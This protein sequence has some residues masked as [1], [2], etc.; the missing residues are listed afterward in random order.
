MKRCVALVSLTVLLTGGLAQAAVEQG[1]TEINLS[2]S[3]SRFTSG[4][5]SGVSGNTYKIFNIAGG[6]DYFVTDN[7]S[8]G[9]GL[10]YTDY[11]QSSYNLNYWSFGARGK[12]HFVPENE[13]VPYVG[14][15]LD[16]DHGLDI[17]TRDSDNN[18]PTSSSGRQTAWSWGPLVGVR[19]EIN[20]QID[21]YVEYNYIFLEGDWNNAVQLNVETQQLVR[22]GFVHQFN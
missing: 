3:Y 10:G 4:N 19:F 7:I 20:P 6:Y 8:A 5:E 12:W 18:N 1:D 9:L 17:G 22:F 21:F 13:L 15:R 14:L 16:Y 11:N 2:G